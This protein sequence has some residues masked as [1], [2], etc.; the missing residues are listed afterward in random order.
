MN[1]REVG[2][3]DILRCGYLEV[4]RL[5]DVPWAVNILLLSSYREKGWGSYYMCV[6]LETSDSLLALDNR[7]YAS[8]QQRVS[9]RCAFV[10]IEQSL[11]PHSLEEVHAAVLSA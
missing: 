10:G 7:H 11:S 9:D 3:S 4:Y 1:D 6:A 5:F 8:S 2:S